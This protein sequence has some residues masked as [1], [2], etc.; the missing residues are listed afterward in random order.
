MNQIDFF[1]NAH[2]HNAQSQYEILNLFPEE[3]IIDSFI[4]SIGIHPCFISEQWEKDLNLVKE[5]SQSPQCKAIGE[6]GLDKNSPHDFSLQI[7][8]FKQQIQLA[9]QLQKPIIIHCVKAFS[10]IISLKKKEKNSTQ[11]IL[12]GFQKNEKIAQELLQNQ[13]ILSVGS[14][15]LYNENLKK[16]IPNIPNHQLLIENDNSSISIEKIYQKI[17]EIKN[18]SIQTLQKIQWNN[19][20]N[21][22]KFNKL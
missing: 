20:K 10:E 16:I 13:M 19:Y 6:C 11:W 4:F 12:H 1:I 3:K 18:I 2:T 8:I 14:A 17:A 9:N 22:F 5:K 15:V 21:I 7:E